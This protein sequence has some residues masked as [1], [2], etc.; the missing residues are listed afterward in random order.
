[1]LQTLSKYNASK[2]TKLIGVT[3]RIHDSAA[4]A[5]ASFILFK[6]GWIP[7]TEKFPM[8]FYDADGTQYL[9][10]PD[11]YHPATGFYSE[12]KTRKLNGKGTKRLADAAMEKVDRDITLGRLLPDKRPYRVLEHAWNHSIQ[13]MACKAAQLPRNMPLVLLYE[14]EQ[15]LNEERRCKRNGIFMLSLENMCGLNVFLKL[16]SYGLAVAFT[17]EGFKFSVQ[18]L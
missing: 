4:E 3:G 13:T 1:M 12:F 11:F 15:D 7:H 10:C 9:A 2:S 17:R 6:H 18:T 5:K 14:K 16:A 8:P